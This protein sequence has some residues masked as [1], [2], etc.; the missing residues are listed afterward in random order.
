MKYYYNTKVKY[1]QIYMN[2][3]L[4]F[5]A[6]YA[7]LSFISMI[8]TGTI[9]DAVVSVLFIAAS[10]LNCVFFRFIDS[11]SFIANVVYNFMFVAYL[12]YI[13]NSATAS[14]L[15]SMCVGIILIAFNLWYFIARRDLFFKDLKTLKKEYEGEDL[16]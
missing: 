16:L 15:F 6:L 2:I 11:F 14:L 1:L 9:A 5:T 12:S 7:V 4:P 3:I 10:L 13:N 8:P